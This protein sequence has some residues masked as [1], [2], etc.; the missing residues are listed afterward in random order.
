MAAPGR[1]KNTGV[2]RLARESG[3]DSTT[4]SRKL[5]R[6]MTPDQIREQGALW[7]QK[8]TLKGRNK[9]RVKPETLQRVKSYVPARRAS[10]PTPPVPPAPP[11]PKPAQA[12][13]PKPS[14]NGHANGRANGRGARKELRIEGENIIQ[15]ELRRA[16]AQANER[17]AKVAIL[18]GDWVP[19]EQVNFW[20]GA[21]I[22]EVRNIIMRM[23]DLGDDLALV[24]DPVECRRILREEAV[25]ALASL[26]LMGIEAA[27][28]TAQTQDK[29]EEGA[30]DET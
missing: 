20:V 24:D 28:G 2:V 17:E 11:S 18:R 30:D 23:E 13:G 7:A 29:D 16:I 25:R 8:G 10:V 9:R 5:A 27:G 21:E 12:A 4:V 3:M 6:G 15:A 1:Q 26:R 14:E 19:R 22:V